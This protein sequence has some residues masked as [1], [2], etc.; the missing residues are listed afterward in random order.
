MSTDFERHL[1]K[2][3]EVILKIGLNLQK[4]QRLLIGSPIFGIYGTPIELA[5][6]VRLVVRKAYQAGARLVDVLWND[7]QMRLTRFQEAPRDSFDEFPKWR[8]SAAYEAAS[9]G[10]AILTFYAEDPELLKDQDPEPV[11]I[12]NKTNWTHIGPA[13]DLLIKN[14]MNWTIATAP[15]E[16]WVDRLFPSLASRDRKAKFWDTIFEICRVTQADPV[17]VWEAHLTELAGRANYL[18]HKKY[19]SLKFSAPGINLTVGLPEGH[20]WKGGRMTS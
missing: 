17:S 8:A 20:L 18:N 12:F 11:G 7:D 10:D 1:D 15:V 6:L 14:S 16:G 19:I 3:A 2:Y 5:P 13:M 9:S 4:G